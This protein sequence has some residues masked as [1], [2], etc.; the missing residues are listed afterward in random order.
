MIVDKLFGGRIGIARTKIAYVAST[1][2][3]SKEIYVMDYD[4]ANAFPLI[5]Y[6]SISIMPSWSPD[7]DKVAYIIYRKGL[8]DIEVMSVLDR[9]LYDF[10]PFRS[11]TETPSWS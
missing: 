4:G 8:P 6:R 2:K 5:G 3:D 11:S 7:G 1:G 10:P 9:C